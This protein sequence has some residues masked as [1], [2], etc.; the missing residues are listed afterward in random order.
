MSITNQA[1]RIAG[2]VYDLTVEGTEDT[3]YTV[4]VKQY[5]GIVSMHGDEGFAVNSVIKA[6]VN[7][8]GEN[9]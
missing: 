5:P 2:K 6:I 4:R 9:T 8:I 3:G 7:K 1:V